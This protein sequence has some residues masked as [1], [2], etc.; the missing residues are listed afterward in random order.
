MQKPLLTER[1]WTTEPLQVST[2]S[3]WPLGH[4]FLYLL[5]FCA[6]LVFLFCNHLNSSKPLRSNPGAVIQP[7]KGS[8]HGPCRLFFAPLAPRWEGRTGVSVLPGG[9]LPWDHVTRLYNPE[10]RR[11]DGCW[12]TGLAGGLRVS[13]VRPD[14]SS[15]PPRVA[16]TLE[17]PAPP[18]PAASALGPP[19]SGCNR[20][21]GSGAAQ[22]T[23]LLSKLGG[24]GRVGVAL[25]AVVLRLHAGKRN[26]CHSSL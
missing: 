3:V 17:A 12:L 1:L 6:R 2:A 13:A 14:C 10:R 26:H 19:G 22:R 8:N 24:S 16:P 11:M 15:S 9:E 4:H 18:L 21:R 7:Q 23:T 5:G 20:R 25:S